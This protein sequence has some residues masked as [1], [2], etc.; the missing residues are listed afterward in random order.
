M[1]VIKQTSLI[2][3]VMMVF[4]HNSHANGG[5]KKPHAH[6]HLFE[7]ATKL[8]VE[9]LI[10][11]IKDKGGL[12]K[13]FD[14]SAVMGFRGKNGRVYFLVSDKMVDTPHKM[15]GSQWLAVGVGQL[16][17]LGVLNYISFS[18]VI[19]IDPAEVSPPANQ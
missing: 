3:L 19:K 11:E 1:N 6:M 12:P 5:E 15:T 17:A 18:E 13:K 9:D 16:E 14:W 4:L 8:T 2:I 10:V 7:L